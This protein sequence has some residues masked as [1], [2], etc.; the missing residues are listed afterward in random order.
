MADIKLTTFLTSIADAIRYA[1]GSADKIDVADFEGRIKALSSSS[2]YPRKIFRD[3]SII[4]DKYNT[5][6]VGE[7]ISVI[8]KYPSWNGRMFHSASL[9]VFT[10]IGVLEDD[11]YYI[12]NISFTQVTYDYSKDITGGEKRKV[13]FRNC[14]FNANSDYCFKSSSSLNLY[15]GREIS[16]IN[17]E[18][19]NA[20][21][22]CVQ[23]AENLTFINCKIHNM[24]SDGGKVTSNGGYYNCLFYDLGRSEGSHADGIQT[25][26]YN[27]DF[28]IEN[29]RFDMPQIENVTRSNACIFFMQEAVSE[30]PTIKDC[31][32]N[33][34]QY[35][36]YFGHKNEPYTEAE[37]INN[38]IIDNNKCGRLKRSGNLMNNDVYTTFTQKML[39]DQT[40]LFVSSIFVDNGNINIVTTNYT[41][42]AKTLTVKS[43]LGDTTFSVNA[44][45]NNDAS[46]LS[47]YPFDVI[48]TIPS[49]GITSF[50]IFDGDTLIRTWRIDD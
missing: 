9:N 27:T 30:S 39:S 48:Y 3:I 42:H 49:E 21:S 10:N 38:P 41:E 45:P 33:G 20:S 6:C 25:T 1:E 11:I 44:C 13:V 31:M 35:S 43:N 34:G 19:E 5:G 8:T 16:F 28:Y 23:P 15:N 22:A 47:D 29:C 7:L 12:D 40:E 18:F 17:C 24:G 4:P 37:A 50:K 2:D 32:F 36:L 46:S 26:G 14:Y